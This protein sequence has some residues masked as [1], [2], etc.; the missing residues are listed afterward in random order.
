MSLRFRLNLAFILIFGL[1]LLGTTTLVYLTELQQARETVLHDAEVLLSVALSTRTYTVEQVRPHIEDQNSDSFLPQ[2][3]PSYAAQE[4]FLLFKGSHPE[5]SYREAALNPTNL[6]DRASLWETE[7]INAFRDNPTQEQA[8]GVRQTEDGRQFYLARPI[9]ITNPACLE[10]HSEP[11]NAPAT[12][13]ARYGPNNGFGWELDEIVGAQII[14]VPAGISLRSA[15]ET[16]LTQIISLLSIFTLLLIAVNLLLSRMFI[17]PLERIA[18]AAEKYSLGDLSAAEFS[19]DRHDEVGKLES[20]LN[21]L[22]R[23]LDTLLKRDKD[24]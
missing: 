3:V 17:E 6:R 2:T 13:L 5:F 20:A 14:T 24:S 18:D 12:M 19:G 10:C 8:T 22:R 4:T 9:K 7:L 11:E 1:G 16:T 23:S 21:R 15:R